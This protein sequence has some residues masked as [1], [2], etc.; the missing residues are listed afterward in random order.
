METSLT[1]RIHLFRNA[2]QV[3]QRFYF[4]NVDW[5]M[6]P[7]SSSTI[8]SIESFLLYRGRLMKWRSFYS[9]GCRPILMLSWKWNDLMVCVEGLTFL[10]TTFFADG[11]WDG[12]SQQPSDAAVRINYASNVLVES[13]SFLESLSGNGI[14]IRNTT[15]DSRV[16]RCLFDSLGQGGVA[17][18]G[19]DSS[20]VPQTGGTV[21]GNNTQPKRIDI[22]HNVVSDIGRNLVHVAG[23]MRAASYIHVHHN[24]ISHATR[25]GI[26]SDSF[27]PHT[28]YK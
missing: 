4:E 21:A 15:T 23:V 25:Y 28:L 7:A 22:D 11:Y 16:T 19:Y 24:R 17:M 20:P 13:C 12:P 9:R 5:M 18:F 10:D 26:Q 14:A 2:F 3:N 1:D 8:A 27:Y 6:E